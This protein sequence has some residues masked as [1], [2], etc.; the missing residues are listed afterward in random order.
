MSFPEFDDPLWPLLAQVSRPSRYSGSEWRFSR[1]GGPDLKSVEPGLKKEILS[2]CL[3]FP[4]VYEIGMSYYGFQILSPFLAELPGIAVDR[5]YCPWIDMEALLRKNAVP[6]TSTERS[7]PL[8]DFDVVGFTLQ[9]ELGYTNVL[10]MLDLGGIPLRSENRKNGHP[11]VMAGGPGAL[12]PEPLSS[13]IDIF[14]VGE[15]EAILPKLLSVLRE[16]V[17]LGRAERLAE[18]ARLPGV[19]VPMLFKPSEPFVPIRREFIPSFEE[20]YIPDSMIVPSVGIVHDRAALEVFRGCSRG[21]R[22]CQAGMTNR[23]TRERAPEAI[24]DAI[25]EL[26]RRT[27]WEEAGLL[28]L[29]TCD[30]SA[31]DRVI[32]ELTPKFVEQGVHLSLPSLRMDSFS[33]NLAARFQKIR[34][35]GLT[36][37]P[38][39]GTQRLRDVINKGID[40]ESIYACLEEVFSKGWDKVK[41]YFMMGL[42]TET[43]EDLDSIIRMAHESIKLARRKGRK[44][45]SVAISVAGFV[46]KAHTPFQ[47]EAQNSIEEFKSKGRQLKLQIKDRA[48]SLKY[49]EPEQ[50]FL[51]GVFA[52]GDRKLGDVIER[53]WQKGARFDGWSET[54]DLTRWLDAFNECGLNPADYVRARDEHE[55]LPWDHINAGVTKEFLLKER[56]A[57]YAASKTPAC[58]RNGSVCGEC[59]LNCE[60]RN[61]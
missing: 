8:S 52:R 21:C 3:A 57:A 56:A 15:G 25:M 20:T 12:V 32:E 29:A 22:F 58:G 7:M 46:P 35:G 9:H 61:A 6:L 53:A 55:Q 50:S 39:A 48:L 31:L 4:D 33:V 43:E 16:T 10:T 13:F 37:A 23:P 51:E 41:L 27:G 24:V 36:F 30:Y 2:V 47:W 18:C 26:V 54:F 49:H 28:S 59:G 11:I 40:E 14:C 34:R 5:A 17:G 42:P 60:V 45:A 1:A 44:R 38:E 19:Y